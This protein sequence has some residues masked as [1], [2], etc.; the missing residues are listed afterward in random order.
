[1]VTRKSSAAPEERLAEAALK[2][3]AKTPW[4]DLRLVS[5]AKAARVPMAGMQSLCAAKPALFG[6][7]L[8]RIG[9]WCA[10]RY[11]PESG[12]AHDR[13]FEVPM[14]WFEVLAPHKKAVRSLYEGLKRDPFTL[15]AA[16]SEIVSAASWLLA[17]AEADT[18]PALPLRAL[19]LA[20]AL[21]RAVPVWL[22]DDKDLTKTMARLDMDIRRGET[23]LD[24]MRG[25][26]PQ[27]EED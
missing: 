11:V 13:L 22:E 15:M 25:A 3:L 27:A 24:R 10:A 17:L 2:L 7:I 9:A 12:T 26:K 19:A 18:G 20:A 4:Q 21:G 8:H 6:L 16:R 14:S 23:I 5:V 1:M